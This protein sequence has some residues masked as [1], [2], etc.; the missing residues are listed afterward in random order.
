MQELDSQHLSRS[1]C[2]LSHTEAQTDKYTDRVHT[3]LDKV[4]QG[5]GGPSGCSVAVINSSHLQNLLGH[6][7]RNNTSTTWCWD[8]SHCDGATL[9]GHLGGHSV[10]LANFVTPVSSSYRD[11]C[12]LGLND[13]SS[14]GSGNLHG[15]EYVDEYAAAL[16]SQIQCQWQSL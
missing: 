5:L 2:E 9:A 13:G 6:T 4:T 7:R 8:K 15:Q 1:A 12:H 3:Y 10:R 11:A 14:N 16:S